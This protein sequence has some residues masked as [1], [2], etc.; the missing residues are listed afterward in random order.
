MPQS[1]PPRRAYRGSRS[2]RDLRSGK[3][4][5]SSERPT[6]GHRVSR[7]VPQQDTS[8]ASAGGPGPGNP[9]T[10]RAPRGNLSR[11]R[12]GNRRGILIAAG[13]AGIGGGGL[14]Y[15]RKRRRAGVSKIFNPYTD[16]LVDVGKTTG[17]QRHVY[18]SRIGL[19]GQ[20]QGKEIRREAN[21][22]YRHALGRRGPAAGGAGAA[23]GAGIGALRGGRRGAKIG[24]AVGGGGG[25]YGAAVSSQMKARRF[26]QDKLDRQEASKAH[27][28]PNTASV[29]GSTGRAGYPV[30]LPVG[31]SSRVSPTTASGSHVSH[32]ND[33]STTTRRTKRRG[34]PAALAQY[35]SGSQEQMRGGGQRYGNRA[36]HVGKNEQFAATR[37]SRGTPMSG[38]AQSGRVGRRL[39][40]V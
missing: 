23:I 28:F 33:L 11:L 29:R 10:H 4:D 31:N 25:V 13:A 19:P 36:T 20:K 38:L 15:D 37:G 24:A 35:R 14:V 16:E 26:A 3:L 9:G 39:T 1:R 21:R 32:E 12:P 18:D 2:G 40:V 30:L 34:S 8:T 6:E 22:E 17:F 5:I 27:G 7:S